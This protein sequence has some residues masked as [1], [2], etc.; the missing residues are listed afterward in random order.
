[1]TAFC[2]ELVQQNIF[3]FFRLSLMI[4]GHT[5]FNVDR[6]FSKIAIS[7][8][9]SDVFNSDDMAAVVGYTHTL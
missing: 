9:R 4:A 5:K 2:Q 3:T 6:L 1:M 8:N 7:Y